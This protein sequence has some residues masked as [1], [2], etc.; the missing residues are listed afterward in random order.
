MDITWTNTRKSLKN[1]ASILKCGKCGN[2]PINPVRYTTCGDFFCSNC[3][4]NSKCYLCGIPVRPNE[5]RIDHTISNLVRECDIIADVIKEDNLW[6]MNVE[7]RNISLRSNKLPTNSQNS[8]TVNKITNY[9]PKNV[10]KNINKRNPKGETPLHTACIKGQKETVISLLNAGANP[11]TKDNANWSPLQECI[12]LGFYDI[13]KLLLKAG[14][15]PNIPGI[16]NKT[17]LHEATINNRVREAKLLLEYHANRDVYDQFGKKPID[18]CKSKEMQEVLSDGDLF[19][20]NTESEND[21]NCTTN[22]SLY[23]TNLIVYLSNLNKTMEANNKNITKLTYDVMLAILN[24]KWLLTSEWIS[25]CLELEDIHQM[26]LELFE[27]SGCPIL[28][29]PKRARLNQEHQNPR[30]F[31]RCSFYLALHPDVVYPI[32]DINLTKKELTKLINAGGGTILSRE[33][34]PEDIKN[35]EQYISFHTACNPRHPLYKCTHYIIYAPGNDEPR[36]KYNMSHIR[37]LP[38]IWLIECIEKF[39]LLNPSYLGL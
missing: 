2:K 35:K 29:I 4:Q 5:I 16:D 31:D 20:N 15:F 24:G 9:V 23:Q 21:L 7:T 39:T 12:N 25:M 18:Y 30:L 1:F 14:A 38:L 13:C 6:N 37:S 19:S 34:N 32:G 8:N 26:E 27:V 10:I 36:I 11:N 28:G 33:P 3:A 17:P 22:Q